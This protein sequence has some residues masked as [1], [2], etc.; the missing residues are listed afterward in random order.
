MGFF[1]GF[2]ELFFLTCFYLI[3]HFLRLQDYNGHHLNSKENDFQS[4]I[5]SDL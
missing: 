1:M 4:T 5:K 2:K 3:I